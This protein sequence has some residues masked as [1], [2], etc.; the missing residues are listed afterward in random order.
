[1]ETDRR[2]LLLGLFCAALPMSRAVADMRATPAFLTTGRRGER[3][4]AI[5]LDRRG[6]I[7]GDFPLPDRGHGFAVS[8]DGHRAVAFARRPGRFAISFDPA[9]MQASVP[10]PL[11]ADR[12]FYGHGLFSA[13]G[14]RLFATQND[15][16]AERGV[17]AVHDVRRNW[18][19]IGEFATH[20][21]G[22]HECLLSDDGRSAVI[23][24]G[25]ILTHPD[26]PRRKLNLD[27]MESTLVRLDLASGAL[28]ARASLPPALY[29]LSI[30]HLAATPDGATWFCCQ[31]EGAATGQP[32]LIG[33]WD[34][35]GDIRLIDLPAAVTRSM[36]NYAGS[37]AAS[38][39]GHRIAVTSPRGGIIV[40]LDGR[41]G[42]LVETVSLADTCGIAPTGDGFM[43]TAG[44]GAIRSGD[45]TDAHPDIAWDNHLVTLES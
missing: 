42:A 36:R 40:I 23:A 27:S 5:A 9:T 37:I 28:L 31:H 7:T 45:N 17:L 16:E 41:S 2:T 38:H 34:R 43:A 13:D 11:P 3:F 1:M 12:H 26:Y 10:L 22:P 32:P 25:G 35:R 20:G 18:R 30:R 15:F 29:Q 39:D 8:R 6:R 4:H 21:I 14:D 44:T 33:R 19:R 24:N